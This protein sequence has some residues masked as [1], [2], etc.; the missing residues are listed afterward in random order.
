MQLDLFGALD[1]L[2]KC[3]NS[4][5]VETVPEP[6]GPHTKGCEGSAGLEKFN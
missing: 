2:I 1:G 4:F 6:R 5:W 3:I